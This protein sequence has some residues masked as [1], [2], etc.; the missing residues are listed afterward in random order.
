D[1]AGRLIAS[2][3]TVEKINKRPSS[4]LSPFS[5]FPRTD[6]KALEIIGNEISARPGHGGCAALQIVTT[7]PNNMSPLAPRRSPVRRLARFA[8]PWPARP[9][10]NAFWN[11]FSD[12]TRAAA[13]MTLERMS[14]SY[15]VKRRW[16]R[17]K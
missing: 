12:N 10:G 13:E 5:S 11:E 4:F 7:I 2:S 17:G 8:D 6:A 1:L 16:K 3:R 9:S 15:I 14:S